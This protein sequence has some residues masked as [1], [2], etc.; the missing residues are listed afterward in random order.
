MKTTTTDTY[1]RAVNVTHFIFIIFIL[2]SN[3]RETT[4][5]S[6]SSHYLLFIIII[7]VLLLFCRCICLSVSS[8]ALQLVVCSHCVYE[9]KRKRWENSLNR[10]RA[11]RKRKKKKQI[12]TFPTSSEYQFMPFISTLHL[13]PFTLVTFCCA[14]I[15]IAFAHFFFLSSSVAAFIRFNGTADNVFTLTHG[16]LFPLIFIEIQYFFFACVSTFC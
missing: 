7:Y 15:L 10:A 2:Q 14:N 1:A 13:S 11:K 9:W 4:D 12:K 16:E 5:N 8:F 6:I 3:I